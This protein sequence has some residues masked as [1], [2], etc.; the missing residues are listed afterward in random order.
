MKMASSKVGPNLHM[1][2]ASSKAHW[3]LAWTIIDLLDHGQKINLFISQKKK[4][5]NLVLVKLQF[6]VRG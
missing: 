1:K 5:Q 4:S 3:G 2:M 6:Y